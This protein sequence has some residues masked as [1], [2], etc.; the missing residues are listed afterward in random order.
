MLLS[1]LSVGCKYSVPGN[2]QGHVKRTQYLADIPNA[3]NFT[4]TWHEV[5]ELGNQ[6]V[7]DSCSGE[8]IQ[9]SGTLSI[10]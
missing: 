3:W 6:Y 1:C 9:V 7:Y 10:Y 2:W 8:C 5:S 4:L